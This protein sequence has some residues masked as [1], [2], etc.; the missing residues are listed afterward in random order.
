MAKNEQ[1]GLASE[2][3]S[4]MNLDQSMCMLNLIRFRDRAEY[5]PGSSETP[6]AGAEAYDRYREQVSPLVRAAGGAPMLSRLQ[7][8]VG[9]DDEWDLCFAVY[10]PSIRAFLSMVND[11]AYQAVSHHRAAAVADSRGTILQFDDEGVAQACGDAIG[12]AR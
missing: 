1:V 12:H 2:R 11:P 5:A 4:G 7:G 9:S 8:L 10:Y 6:C 3:L